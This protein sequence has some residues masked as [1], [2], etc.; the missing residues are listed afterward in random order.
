[1]EKSGSLIDE[2]DVP[3]DKAFQYG[4]Y[5]EMVFDQKH[6]WKCF[7]DKFEPVFCST[8]RDA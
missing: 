7:E 5:D 2:Y 8:L 1:M 6:V 4:Y 3:L